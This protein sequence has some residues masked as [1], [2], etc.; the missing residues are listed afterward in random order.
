M[1]PPARAEIADFSYLYRWLRNCT[2]ARLDLGRLDLE[3]TTS[4]HDAT[5]LAARV[6]VYRVHGQFDRLPTSPVRVPS[7]EGC[8]QDSNAEVFLERRL[9]VSSRVIPFFAGVLVLLA[10]FLQP[11]QA[12][13][14]P[15]PQRGPLPFG[16]T[17]CAAKPDVVQQ[18]F[19]PLAHLRYF[20]GAEILLNNNGVD[21]L[22][23]RPMWF[24]RG[25]DPVNGRQV[26][27][28]PLTMEVKQ[29]GALLPDGVP[30]SRVDGLLLEYRRQDDGARRA[31]GPAACVHA[32]R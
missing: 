27:M 29:I 12:G 1:L 32:S 21:P 14:P 17:T 24:V 16:G 10:L 5:R 8:A 2:A 25:S 13:R 4:R 3:D 9:L 20:D 30:A 23:V 11:M 28:P 26:T 22:V 15:Q 19:V 7:L 6:I 31:S 18:M